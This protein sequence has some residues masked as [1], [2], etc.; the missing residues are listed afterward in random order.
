MTPPPPVP[1][2]F[3]TPADG[4]VYDSLRRAANGRVD[5][6]PAVIARCETVDDVVDALA[7][8]RRHGLKVSARSRAHG[9]TGDAIVE[10]GL[11][12]DLR[13]M[14]A[15]RVEPGTG[16]LTAQP[17]ARIGDVLLHA[18]RAGLGFPAGSHTDVGVG[19]FT[20]GGGYSDLGRSLGLACDRVVSLDVV[21]AAGDRLTVD[22]EHEPELF[23]AL[24]GAGGGHFVVVV[25]FTFQLDPQ[26]AQLPT[27]AA[28]YPL[29]DLERLLESYLP[30]FAGAAPDAAHVLFGIRTF[31]G[32]PA[33]CVLHGVYNGEDQGAAEVEFARLSGGLTPLNADNR[34]E[35]YFNHKRRFDS[36]PTDWPWMIKSRFLRPDLDPRA[37]A[38]VVDHHVRR[39]PNRDFYVYLAPMGGAIARGD[40][41]TSAFAHRGESSFINILGLWKH[42]SGAAENM[43]W[44]R[45][46][47][48]AI[49]PFC[50]ASVY[51]NE[52]DD[53]LLDWKQ[54]YFGANYERLRAVKRA[55]D[56]DG[57]LLNTVQN[58]R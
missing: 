20:L 41:E 50:T 42:P 24:R 44:V 55:Y 9:Y 32:L 38:A 15:I 23:W 8:A 19:G 26:P 45:D 37:I 33:C 13:A 6:R 18:F 14:R 10:R 30:Y 46:H 35:T 28:I 25:S 52:I 39:A 51:V 17:G 16:R 11:V 5:K 27:M 40:R 47:V 53:E 3:V 48:A 7:Y 29:E 43:A 21:T 54:A 49:Q 57:L 36:E 34:M 56:P 12:L 58:L 1:P 2:S 22:R 4:A 31:P